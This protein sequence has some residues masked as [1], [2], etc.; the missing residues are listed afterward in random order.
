M[1]GSGFT[2][3]APVGWTVAHSGGATSA[4]SGN[5]DRL[6]VSTFKLEKPY[7][8]ALFAAVTKEL[9][10]AADGL[11]TQLKGTVADRSTIEVDGRKARAYRI[12]YGGKTEQITFVLEGQTEYE[13][14]CRRAT[15]DST[16]A[17]DQLFSTFAVV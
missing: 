5:L 10:H 1:H 6:E 3:G 15:S 11:A 14:L 17:C 4:S 16:A 7:R 12:D 9:D 8:P 13:L 2:F